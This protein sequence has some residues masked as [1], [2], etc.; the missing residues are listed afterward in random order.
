MA[1]SR[2]T[3]LGACHWLPTL[4]RQNFNACAP[5]FKAV[6]TSRRGVRLSVFTVKACAGNSL[7]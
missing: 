6:G 1:S 2:R 3:Y 4:M 5:Q 7:V